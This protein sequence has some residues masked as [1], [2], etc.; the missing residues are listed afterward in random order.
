MK[1]SMRLTRWMA[2]VLVVAM[3]TALVAPAAMAD[4][5]RRYKGGYHRSNHRSHGSVYVVRRSSAGPAIAGF[6]GGLFLGAALAHAAPAGY[7]YYDPYCEERFVSLEIYRTHLH[8]HHHPRVIRVIEVDGG[9]YV[10][11][12]RYDDGRWRAW[13]D[14]DYRVYDRDRGRYHRDHDDD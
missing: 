8:R 6:L 4:R 14:D 2:V 13:D 1:P 5:G 12:Y 3:M 7:A 9:S 11:S 10:R